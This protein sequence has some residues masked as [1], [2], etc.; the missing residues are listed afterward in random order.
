VATELRSL[1]GQRFTTWLAAWLNRC[2]WMCAISRFE[3]HNEL[4]SDEEGLLVIRI[5]RM[6]KVHKRIETKFIWDR[7][8]AR[9]ISKVNDLRLRLRG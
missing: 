7:S 5:S 2:F 8:L 4:V 6:S 1:R 3:N 9:K